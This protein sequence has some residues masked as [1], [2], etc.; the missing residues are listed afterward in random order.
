MYAV[1]TVNAMNTNQ[2]SSA[3]IKTVIPLP[4]ARY[5]TH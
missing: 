2:Q 3:H 5:R 1:A 4:F